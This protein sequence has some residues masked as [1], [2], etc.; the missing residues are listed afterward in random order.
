MLGKES[1]IRNSFANTVSLCF[2][3]LTNPTNFCIRQL[4]GVDERREE[5]LLRSV[6]SHRNSSMS[7]TSTG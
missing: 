5:N 1:I 6:L 4:Q 2:E 7:L 3:P